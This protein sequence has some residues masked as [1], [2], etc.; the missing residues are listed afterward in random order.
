MLY[1]IYFASVSKYIFFLFV[2]ICLFLIVGCWTKMVDSGMR[3]R[4]GRRSTHRTEEEAQQDDN[5]QQKV[6][7][8]VAIDATQQDDVD[9][10]QDAPV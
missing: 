5:A 9:A 2:L 6:E 7:Q 1:F 4:R 10:Q 8:H 3:M